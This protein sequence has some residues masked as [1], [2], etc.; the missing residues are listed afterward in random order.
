MLDVYH[1][2]HST[3]ITEETRIA[4]LTTRE[5]V[6]K[7]GD[8]QHRRCPQT[9]SHCD[10]T[11]DHD[12]AC[13]SGRHLGTLH[14]HMDAAYTDR[15]DGKISEEFWRRKQADWEAEEQRVKGQISGV[16]ADTFED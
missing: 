14:E 4:Y 12:G 5:I 15:L 9:G 8:A 2:C 3:D 16:C 13:T 10:E 11:E 1:V 7:R 6:S